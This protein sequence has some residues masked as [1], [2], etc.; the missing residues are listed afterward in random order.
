MPWELSMRNDTE[1]TV[2]VANVTKSGSPSLGSA[3]T[4][5][6]DP[7][8]NVRVPDVTFSVESVRSWRPIRVICVGPGQVR[9]KV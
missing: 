9:V 5:I 1:V 8:L 7:S 3:P 2:F 6:V 4:A